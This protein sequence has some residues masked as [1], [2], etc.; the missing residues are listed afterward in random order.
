MFTSCCSV[1]LKTA[2]PSLANCFPACKVLLAPLLLQ[3]PSAHDVFLKSTQKYAP[4][5]SLGCWISSSFGP[6]SLGARFQTCE[7]FI[8]AIFQ[9]FFRAAVNRE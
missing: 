7:P 4:F 5:W 9:F 6:F 2:I 3:V 8:S 1:G